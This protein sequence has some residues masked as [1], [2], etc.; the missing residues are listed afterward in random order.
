VQRPSELYR[1]G[2]TYDCCVNSGLPGS[3]SLFSYDLYTQLKASAPEFTELAAF[4]A[5]TRAITIGRPDPDAPGEALDAAYVSGNYFAMLGLSA[6]AG[7]LVQPNDDHPGAPPVAVISHRAWTQRFQQRPD[8]IG[9]TMLFNGVAGTIIGIAPEDFYGETLRPDPPDVWIPLSSE[10]LMQPA[11]QLLHAKP[12]HWLYIMGR[13][14]PGTSMPP[15]EARLTARVQQ[16]LAATVDLSSS[17]RDQLPQQHIKVVRAAAGVGSMR[18]AVA[19]SLTLLQAVAGVVLLIACANLAN[20]LLARG[21][22]R[23]T[24]TAVRIALGAT[25]GRLAAQLLTESVVLSCIGGLAGLAVAHAGAR[26]IINLT[27]RGATSIPVDPT[28]SLLVIL[29]AFGVS[30]VTA[31]VFGAAPALIGSRSNPIEAMRGAGRSTADRGSA[32]RQTLIALQVALSLVLITCAG[33]LGRSLDNLQKQDFGFRAEGLYNA[34]LAPSIAMTPPAELEQLYALTQERLAR[35]PGIQRAAFSL[36]S[37]MS[38]DNWA[39]H[40]T[41]DGHGTAER[42]V[43]SWNRVSRRYFEVIGVPVVRGRDF[44]E[45]DGPS[46]PLVAIVSQTFATRFFGDQDPIGRRIGFSNSAGT[47][48]REFEIVGVVGDTKYQDARTAPYATFFLPFLQES[49]ARR[50]VGGGARIDRSHYAQA[51]LIRTRSVVPNLDGELRRAL[52]EVD[53]RLIIRRV[54]P[55]HEQLAGHFN[56]ERLIARLSIAFGSV[57]LLLAC[58]GIYGVTA[59]SVTRRTREIGIRMAVG[60]SRPRVLGTI[61]RG[62]FVQLA[63]G[64]AVGL[65][66]ALATGRLL[67]ST[68]FGVGPRD[69]LVLGAGLAVLTMATATAALLPA[70]RAAGMDPVRAL[71]MD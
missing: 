4:Q 2:D 62:A 10:P 8:V 51:L 15:L 43:A 61:L 60:A 32:L 44:D 45:R 63:I 57:A 71:R 49:A 17:E 21:M 29:F 16:W 24:E 36:Y 28:P 54:L 50:A 68:L 6:A 5:N 26:T 14:K 22:A 47:G 70:R 58:L 66:A 69:P 67:Q 20:L 35:I 19:P 39:S 33:L 1:L 18:E 59:Y 52:G 37:P 40:I 42:L 46:G 48:P 53:R 7:R 55:M 38:G 25:R 31:L 30:L 65:P 41:V 13:L 3:F 34:W 11:A 12:S 56:L 9:S 27:F 64:V 23:R